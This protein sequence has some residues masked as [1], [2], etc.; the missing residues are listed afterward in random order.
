[1]TT[2]I[3]NAIDNVSQ[4]TLNTL[5][6]S[7]ASNPTARDN[8]SQSNRNI[9]KVSENVE[10]INQLDESEDAIRRILC[11]REGESP[12]DFPTLDA[13]AGNAELMQSIAGRQVSSKILARS[14]KAIN[15]T[16]SSQTAMAKLAVS[17]IAIE[18]I[19]ASADA[20]QEFAVSDIAMREFAASQTA[21]GE[22]VDSQVAID[23]IT[24]SS[25]AR[26]NVISSPIA[27][28][29]FVASK[30]VMSDIASDQAFMSEATS[31]P[32]AMKEIA[33]SQTAMQELGSSETAMKEIAD[34]QVAM[35]EIDKNDFAV[36]AIMC[37][38]T[39]Q[40]PTAFANADEIAQNATVMA[41]IADNDITMGAIASSKTAMGEIATSQTAIDQITL[42]NVGRNNIAS[43]STAISQIASAQTGEPEVTLEQE[44]IV[45]LVKSEAATAQDIIALSN[46]EISNIGEFSIKQNF[47]ASNAIIDSGIGRTTFGP[48]PITVS[49]ISESIGQIYDLDIL[50]PMPGVGAGTFISISDPDA[51]LNQVSI[52][53]QIRVRQ[54]YD[55]Q[56]AVDPGFG[57]N[58]FKPQQT[59]DNQQINNQNEGKIEVEYESNTATESSEGFGTGAFDGSGVFS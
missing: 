39:G 34:S 3:I 38:T 37:G 54:Q 50:D 42:S 55:I 21:M 46:L 18:E 35:A 32:T 33:E 28:Q 22:I 4:S 40:D 29:N 11:R 30:D 58:I 17:Q 8:L 56:S 31:S 25:I 5:F 24:E 23:E 51:N 14:N 12:S 7:I 36:R 16:S 1:M 20:I 53:D 48:S 41:E 59:I 6:A 19:L 47:V 27:M 44:F 15:A 9:D 13:V 49:S 10:L 2:P 57:G 45:Q 52:Q 43:S 26:S